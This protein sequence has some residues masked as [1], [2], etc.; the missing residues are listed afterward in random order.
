MKGSDRF[1]PCPENCEYVVRVRDAYKF[2]GNKNENFGV[3]SGLNMSIKRN[4]M[5][6]A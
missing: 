5:Y 1:N 2:Y 6:V 3:L 4:S